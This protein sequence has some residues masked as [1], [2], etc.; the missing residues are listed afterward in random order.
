LNGADLAALARDHLEE[1]HE[2]EPAWLAGSDARRDSPNLYPS[3]FTRTSRSLKRD[4]AAGASPSIEN[5][6][7]ACSGRCRAALSRGR[8]QKAMDE[9]HERLAKLLRLALRIVEAR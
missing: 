1:L 5:R 7:R 9:K 4:A 6:Q 8:R 2:G 3:S